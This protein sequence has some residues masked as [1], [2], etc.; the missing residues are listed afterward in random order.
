MRL[1]RLS[2]M[3]NLPKERNIAE[4]DGFYFGRFVLTLSVAAAVRSRQAARAPGTK[5]LVFICAES[6]RILSNEDLSAPSR[7]ADMSYLVLQSRGRRQSARRYKIEVLTF[8]YFLLRT[9]KL[10]Q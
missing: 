5:Q 8:S 4:V 1:R 9:Y 3:H 7:L 10:H 2:L 6:I